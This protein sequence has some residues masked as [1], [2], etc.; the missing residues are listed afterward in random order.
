M[1]S[2]GLRVV[3]LELGVGANTPDVSKY[4]FWKMAARNPNATYLCINLSE[5]YA[6][7]E[8]ARQSIC[9]DGDIGN[10]LCQLAEGLA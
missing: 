10:I 4:P 9:M 6:P 5:A 8:I 1:F 7:K 2:Q 3:L